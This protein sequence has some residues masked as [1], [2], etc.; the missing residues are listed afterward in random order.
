MRRRW[1]DRTRILIGE[2]NIEKLRRARVV[3]L[4]LGGVGG[5]CAEA[6]V[7]SCIGNLMIV[8]ADII[9]ITNINRQ[10]IATHSNIGKSKVDEMS[11]R[12]KL[13]NPEI[14]IISKNFFCLPDNSDF[15]FEYKPD[16]IVDAIDT[17]TMKIFLA[18]RSKEN[19]INLVSCMG[20]GNRLDP[21]LIKLGI[22]E[23]TTGSG[24]VVSR[25][26]RSKLRKDN[27]LDLN[28]VYSL[29]KPKKIVVR[30]NLNNNFKNS[31]ASFSIVPSVAGYFLAY[32]VI[33][34]LIN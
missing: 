28:V 6:L 31:P 33:S 23:D 27:I 19:N 32:K 22:L 14:N 20:M 29:E 11:K 34:D 2:E 18:K 15:I 7:R 9:D 12:L 10:L 3:V 16:Y 13:I 21:S 26:I 5:S 4:G 8:D 25:V 1:E 24:C 30:D 17:I